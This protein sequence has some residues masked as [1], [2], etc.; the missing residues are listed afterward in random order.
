[1]GKSFKELL[2]GYAE[3]EI[4][5]HEMVEKLMKDTVK[6]DESRLPQI[7]SAEWELSLSPIFVDVETPLVCKSYDIYIL[8]H[9]LGNCA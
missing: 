3:N 9:I 2:Q 4:Q 7:C 1:M 5:I 8:N 6:A